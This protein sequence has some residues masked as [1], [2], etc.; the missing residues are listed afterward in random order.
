MT[1]IY[2]QRF[3]QNL[4]LRITTRKKPK[5]HKGHWDVIKYVHTRQLVVI[6]YYGQQLTL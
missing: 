2:D 4:F 5:T 3:I 6:R 1:Y